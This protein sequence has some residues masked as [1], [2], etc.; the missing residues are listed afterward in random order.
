MNLHFF[1]LMIQNKHVGFCISVCKVDKN[2][3]FA[4]FK[5]LRTKT[6]NFVVAVSSLLTCVANSAYLCQNEFKIGLFR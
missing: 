5:T 2:P 4:I 6:Q 1:S 3:G